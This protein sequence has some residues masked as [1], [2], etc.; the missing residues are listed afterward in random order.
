MLLLGGRTAC[1]YPPTLVSL[2]LHTSW[3]AK[4]VRVAV[5]LCAFWHLAVVCQRGTAKNVALRQQGNSQNLSRVTQTNVIGWML[6]GD[7]KKLVSQKKRS[8]G[9][10]E[11]WEKWKYIIY[12]LLYTSDRCVSG[13]R[14]SYRSHVYKARGLHHCTFVSLPPRSSWGQTW[15][16]VFPVLP[17]PFTHNAAPAVQPNFRRFHPVHK[18]VSCY[19][20]SEA[21]RMSDHWKVKAAGRNAEYIEPIWDGRVRLWHERSIHSK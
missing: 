1:F 8:Q 16:C 6:W 21:E 14:P 15:Q 3:G 18:N 12:R 2:L 4:L 13:S 20:I 10:E 7:D 5:R 9:A 11:W 19:L 17:L